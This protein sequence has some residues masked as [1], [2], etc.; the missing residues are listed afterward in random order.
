MHSAIA[1]RRARVETGVVVAFVLVLAMLAGFVLYP[2]SRVLVY[3]GLA[4]YLD[5]LS[6]PRW[7]A[8]ARNT[9][10]ITLLSTVS[11]TARL[12]RRS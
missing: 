6:R 8:A 5:V 1:I 9:V 10:F 3:P 11:A 4:D 7:L 2:A 12:A